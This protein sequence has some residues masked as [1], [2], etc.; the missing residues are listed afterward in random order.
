MLFYAQ[1]WSFPIKRHDDPSKIIVNEILDDPL[2]AETYFY[3]AVDW[4]MYSY[5][6]LYGPKNQ[7]VIYIE[8]FRTQEHVRRIRELTVQTGK[9]A[10]FIAMPDPTFIAIDLSEESD[11]S[12]IESQFI[13]TRC[14]GM[15][16]D[17]EW[18]IYLED[19]AYTGKC[20]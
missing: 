17:A 9:K 13:L 12:F 4:G 20:G 14:S 16:E 1:T 18:Q 11:F 15:P 5:Q 2:L 19:S 10:L 3:V 7:S 8:P 6:A